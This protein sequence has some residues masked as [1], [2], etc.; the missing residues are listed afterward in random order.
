MLFSV[1][2]AKPTRRSEGYA[3]SGPEK[4]THQGFGIA[5]FFI[6]VALLFPGLAY[7]T[8]HSYKALVGW[9]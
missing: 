9:Q 3:H 2:L 6:G 5:I 1:V 8:W 7:A 4:R